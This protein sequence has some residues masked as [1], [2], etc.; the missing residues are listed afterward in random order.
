MY[1]NGAGG[2]GQAGAAADDAGS[3][4]ARAADPGRAGEVVRLAAAARAIADRARTADE[5]TAHERHE[6]LERI[7]EAVA[8]LTSAKAHVLAAEA[9]AG[10]W[11]GRGDRDVAAWR[12]RTTRAGAPAAG[13]ELR[14]AHVLTTMPAVEQAFTTTDLSAQHVDVLARAVSRATPT[15]AAALADRDT[16]AE[17]VALG[18]R[19]DGREYAKAVDRFVAQVDPVTVEREHAAQ[20]ERRHLFVTDLPGGT[21]VRGMLDHRAGH[22]LR[23]ALENAEGRPAQD[24][25]RTAE[26]RR[27]D[28][29][30]A[31]ADLALSQ[32]DA[33]GAASRPH[34]SVVLKEPTF[35]ALT[36]AL[37]GD[38]GAALSAP[39]GTR[40]GAVNTS[41]VERLAAS[42]RGVPAPTDEDGNPLPVSEVARLLC[43]CALTRVV[44]DAES[45]PVDVGR[46]QRLY[47]GHLR[48]AVVAR[49]GGCAWAGCG[50]PARWCEVH[51]IRWWDRDGGETSVENGVVLCSY[52][53]HVVHE[54]DL[55][56]ERHAPQPPPRG[57]ARGLGPGALGVSY[58]FR[59]RTGVVVRP[60]T[61]GPPTVGP[62]TVGPPTVGPSAVGSPARPT[63]ASPHT[64]SASASASTP[65]GRSPVVPGS[66]F[67]VR[68]PERGRAAPRG[69]PSE[70]AGGGSDRAE[71]PAACGDALFAL[72]SG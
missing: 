44:V 63:A 31:L 23:L 52:H 2:P 17:L 30:V 6:L 11:K 39:S 25:E 15:V 27:A 72:A 12:G 49:D 64:T 4:A 9:R 51:H 35:R 71:P 38:G 45:R 13:A 70:D 61:V 69:G 37:R 8:A 36:R 62:P 20:Y 50:R 22:R 66:T 5:W 68:Q 10:T 16:Q 41:A 3:S 29:L 58:T 21:Q 18:R 53:H 54:R 43:D 65:A 1:S 59:T 26:Q 46:T 28:G 7:D 57:A 56:I 48:R 42:V 55:L 34:V 67:G 19:L 47:S 33:G 14:S 24:D 40:A 60:P 32:P